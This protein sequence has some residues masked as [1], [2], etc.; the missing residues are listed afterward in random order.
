M[1]ICAYKCAQL[2]FLQHIRTYLI[3]LF[4]TAVKKLVCEISNYK[5]LDILVNTI[6]KLDMLIS[7]S[8]LQD[9]VFY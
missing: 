8:Y 2:V 5:L 7:I 1:L 3:D 4:V 6:H 9:I